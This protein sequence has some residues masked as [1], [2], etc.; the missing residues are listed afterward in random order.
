MSDSHDGTVVTVTSQ[1]EMTIPQEFREKLNID[2]PG[3][4]RFTQTEEGEVVIQSVKRPSDVRGGLA[5]GGEKEERS[6][7]MELRDER[8]G[9]KQKTDKED[10]LSEQ[11]R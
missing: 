11:D 2:M 1:G 5:S 10:G 3:R 9:D 6:A 4:V 7:M 8:D